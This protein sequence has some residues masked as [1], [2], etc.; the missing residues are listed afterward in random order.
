MRRPR[1]KRMQAKE[2]IGNKESGEAHLPGPL[3]DTIEENIKQVVELLGSPIDLGQRYIQIGETTK[4]CGLVYIQGQV[5]KHAID[6]MIIKNIMNQPQ[7]DKVPH[8]GEQLLDYLTA[9]IISVSSVKKESSFDQIILPLLE[10]NTILFVDHTQEALVVCTQSEWEGRSIEEP[11]TEPL[12][13]GPRDG[14]TESVKTNITLL[15]NRIQDYNLRIDIYRTGRRSKKILALGYINGI[16]HDDL[17]KEVKRRL[18]SIDIDD[19]MESGII[20]QWIEDS[21]LSPF[22]QLTGTER[23]DK[24]AASLMNGQFCI[25]LDGTPLYSLHRLQ[26]QIPFILQRIT[27]NDG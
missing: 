1:K 26:L 18:N 17:L 5:D 14:F 15:R 25:I 7:S 24:V 13:R 23:P 10:G 2:T 9:R 22:P 4:R 16:I 21:F 6:E 3:Y 8:N 19:A 20:E 27:T 11:V 12:I